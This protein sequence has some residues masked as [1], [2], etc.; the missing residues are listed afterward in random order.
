VLEIG[1]FGDR[2]RGWRLLFRSGTRRAFDWAAVRTGRAVLVNVFLVAYFD[3]QWR[4]RTSIASGS[5]SIALKRAVLRKAL[6][7]ATRN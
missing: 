4:D 1:Q 6:E 3:T 5:G 7:R 2:A